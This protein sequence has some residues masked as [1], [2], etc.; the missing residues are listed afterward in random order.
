MIAFATKNSEQEIR[1]MWKTVFGDPDNYMDVY[2]KTKYKPENTL[3][4]YEDNK[5]VASLQMLPFMFTFCGKEIPIL[6]LS[7]VATLPQYRKKGYMHQLL[8]KS[9]EVAHERE[10]PLMLLVPQENWLLKFYEKYGFSQTFDPGVK[11]LTILGDN[12]KIIESDLKKAYEIFDKQFRNKDV[13]V[14]KTFDDFCAI[15]AEGK[16]FDYPVKKSLIGMARVIDAQKMLQLF[17][18]CYP[19]KAFGIRIEDH[20]ISHNNNLFCISNGTTSKTTH[21][22]SNIKVDV[23]LLAQLLLGYHTTEMK[24]PLRSLF[25]QKTPQIHYMLE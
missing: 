13:T 9:F 12:K 2:F 4:Y 6:Y 22:E 18:S 19:E 24:E 5:A 8:L 16:L 21:S 15:A 10:I 23:E 20:I 14:Q 11:E 7:G 25:P 3:V 1:D 17:A